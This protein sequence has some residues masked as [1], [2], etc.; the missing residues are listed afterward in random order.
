MA[1][2]IPKQIV[3]TKITQVESITSSLVDQEAFFNS[4]ITSDIKFLTFPNIGHKSAGLAGF[5]PTTH[6][7]GDRCSTN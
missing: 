1:I 2:K 3:L 4:T 6:G 5:E 7:F